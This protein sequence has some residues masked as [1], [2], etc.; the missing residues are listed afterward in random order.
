MNNTQPAMIVEFRG[1]CAFLSNFY[2][3]PICVPGL[4]IPAPTAE[5]AF[6]ALKTRNRE[7]QRWVLDSPMPAIAKRRG[8]S[9]TMRPDWNTARVDAMRDILEAK[10]ADPKL[11]AKLTAIGDAQL[12]EGNYW[13]DQFWGSCLCPK[14]ANTPGR[15]M[16]GELLMQIRAELK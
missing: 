2:N 10:F 7:Q 11:A 5:H 6:Q 12:V 14:H 3:Q 16:L 15:N 13:H 9:V 4:E 1:E 8:R